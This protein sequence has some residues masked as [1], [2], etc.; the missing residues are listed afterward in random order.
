MSNP[1]SLEEKQKWQKKRFGLLPNTRLGDASKLPEME[2]PSNLSIIYMSCKQ[3]L[4]EY[5]MCDVHNEAERIA[6][7]YQRAIDEI[8]G[9]S[10]YEW[11]HSAE[12]IRARCS[13]GEYSIWGT[14]DLTDEGKLIAVLSAEF[15]RGQRACHIIWGA[16][17]PAC[18]GRGVWENLG[19][20][21]D[22]LVEKSHAQYGIVWMATSHNLSQRMIEKV[23]GWRPVGFF[24]GGEHLGGTDG[25]YYRQNVVWYSKLY[26]QAPDASQSLKDMI[27]TKAA[28]RV[29]KAVLEYD[30]NVAQAGSTTT[31]GTWWM[32]ILPLLRRSKLSRL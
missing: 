31:E 25:K 27:L 28:A 19:L 13:T 14:Y 2:W 18:R 21:I 4:L 12:Q 15:I 16:V 29:A 10:E 26:D 6:E 20:F 32:N 5:R 30:D 11:H 8:Y 1:F 22:Q 24:L 17:D 23:P 7:I 9:N 3:H